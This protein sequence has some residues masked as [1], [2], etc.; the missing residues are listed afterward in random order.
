MKTIVSTQAPS[1][2]S[3]LTAPPSEK[4]KNM[5]SEDICQWLKE[6][7]IAAEYIECFR[8]DDI[9]GSVLAEY[10]DDDLKGMG[11]SEPHIRKKIRIQFRKIK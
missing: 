3:L 8:K 9:D 6:K 1:T 11:I 7:H 4:A 5:T 2:P 10:D